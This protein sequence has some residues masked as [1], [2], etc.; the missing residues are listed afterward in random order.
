MK[1]DVQ[2]ISDNGDVLV[3]GAYGP[4]TIERQLSQINK[5]IQK[6]NHDLK[7]VCGL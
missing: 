4:K 7:E 2:D 5:R 3:H 1:I 6:I